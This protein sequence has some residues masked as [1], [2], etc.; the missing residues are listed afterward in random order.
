MKPI[1][2][3][4]KEYDPDAEHCTLCRDDNGVPLDTPAVATVCGGVNCGYCGNQLNLCRT[5]LEQ[6][7]TE[8]GEI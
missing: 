4:Y 5:H 8:L 7:K 6:L 2:K 1:A 3:E